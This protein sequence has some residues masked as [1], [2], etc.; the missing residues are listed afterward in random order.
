MFEP[1]STVAYKSC[2]RGLVSNRHPV[3]YSLQSSRRI[4]LG[5]SCWHCT[6]VCVREGGDANSF[7]AR[8]EHTRAFTSMI[9]RDADKQ[10]SK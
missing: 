4:L 7:I 8:L 6:I 2:C 3:D 10:Q 9:V 5:C 1:R